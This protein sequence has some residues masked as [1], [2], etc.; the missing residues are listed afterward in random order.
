MRFVEALCRALEIPGL[1][2]HG[3]TAGDLS[4]LVAR[5]KEASSMK[6]NPVALTD[7]ELTEIAERAL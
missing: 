3:L 1:A 6:G 2:R 7:A 4:V 5:A